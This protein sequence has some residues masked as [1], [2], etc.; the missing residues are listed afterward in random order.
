MDRNWSQESF[1]DND[2]MGFFLVSFLMNLAG[3]KCEE[4]CFYISRDVLY[5]VFNHFSCTPHDIITFLICIIQKLHY[6]LNNN[7]KKKTKKKNAALHHI[8][9]WNAAV[10][11]HFIGT[12][13]P[14]ISC[15]N[16]YVVHIFLVSPFQTWVVYMDGKEV[17]FNLIYQLLVSNAYTAIHNINFTAF[18]TWNNQHINQGVP[19]TLCIYEL[20][21]W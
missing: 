6:L 2:T 10:I 18:E 13:V 1:H 11:F 3:A 14:S 21:Y 5:S 8:F 16:S 12:L 9:F 15:N 19:I 17:E 4:H 7:K 20:V